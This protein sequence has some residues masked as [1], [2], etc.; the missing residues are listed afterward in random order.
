[1][2]AAMAFSLS[3]YGYSVPDEPDYVQPSFTADRGRLHVEAR[4]N[5]EDLETASAW[6]GANFEV[7]DTLAF[8]VTPMLG[9]VFGQTA[10]IAPGYR[11]GLA[12]RQ[13]E[14]TSE[15][16]YLVDSSDS[17]ENFFYTWSE[18]SGYPLEW[19]RL[20]AVVQRTRA[21][22]SERDIQ[23]GFLVGGSWRQADFTAHLFNPDEDDPTVVLAVGWSS[24]RAP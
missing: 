1:V 3:V 7:G 14:L 6:I 24:S 18:L 8:T 13:L 15:G 10:G 19:L 2:L 16:E 9:A 23:R 5:Y 12:W 20:G 4:Y 21:Y 22:E 11:A 17:S